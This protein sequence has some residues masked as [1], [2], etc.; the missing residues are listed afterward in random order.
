MFAFK[1]T[2]HYL[3]KAIQ[4]SRWNYLD[5]EIFN[6]LQCIVGTKVTM[7]FTLIGRCKYFIDFAI[8]RPVNNFFLSSF[9]RCSDLC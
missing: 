6:C 9:L 7:D 4:K 5:N 1:P 3:V 2:N 8:V